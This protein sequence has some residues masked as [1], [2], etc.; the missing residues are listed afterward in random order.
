MRTNAFPGRNRLTTAKIARRSSR[1]RGPG[2][3]PRYGLSGI[4]R[5]WRYRCRLRRP[6]CLCVSSPGK[7]FLLLRNEKA[8]GRAGGLKSARASVAGRLPAS[9]A[10]FVVAAITTLLRSL[11]V[12]APGRAENDLA[13]TVG[14]WNRKRLQDH[15]EAVT[16]LVRKS[17]PARAPR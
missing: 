14:A 5:H 15:I 6:R 9:R 17:R 13:L 1:W 7:A 12:V 16:L 4:T 11:V 8:A 10:G 3:R 2:C